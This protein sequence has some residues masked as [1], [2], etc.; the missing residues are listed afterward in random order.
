MRTRPALIAATMTLMASIAAVAPAAGAATPDLGV[1]RAHACALS[2]TATLQC[3]GAN[4]FGALGDGSFT[5]S[6]VPANVTGLSADPIAL[7]VGFTHTCAVIT[8]GS[9]QCRGKNWDGQLVLRSA[10]S[11][12]HP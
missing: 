5:D 7:G 10:T 12:H 11:R 2:P 1:G 4:N 9:I 3:R 6:N 8:G